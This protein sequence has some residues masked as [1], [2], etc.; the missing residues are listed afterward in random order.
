MTIKIVYNKLLQGWY[1]VRGPH[2][3][4]LNGRFETRAQAQAW[5]DRSEWKRIE[6]GARKPM[7]AIDETSHYRSE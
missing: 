1:M 3:T 5:L 4:P 7:R 6:R 2:Q